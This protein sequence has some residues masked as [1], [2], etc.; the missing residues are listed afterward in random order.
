MSIPGRSSACE[1]AG[2]P[3]ERGRRSE[4]RAR[5]ARPTEPALGE[6]GSSAVSCISNGAWLSLVERLLWEQKVGGSNPPAP[7]ILTMVGECHGLLRGEKK[8]GARRFS[9]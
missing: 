2:H 7:T 9:R 3:A 1:R 8:V 4:C 5:S 6:G